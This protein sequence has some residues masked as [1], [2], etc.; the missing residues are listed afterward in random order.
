MIFGQYKHAITF[1]LV[2]LA[3]A[4]VVAD[5]GSDDV[6]DSAQAAAPAPPVPAAQP[7]P[8]RTVA[9]T[10]PEW[11]GE[12]V[13]GAEMPE[14][15]GANVDGEGYAVAPAATARTSVASQPAAVAAP[16]AQAGTDAPPPPPPQTYQP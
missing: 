13:G 9:S 12:P 16:A 5:P 7:R 3:L 11:Y 1:A 14:N 10:D 6:A 4:V 15:V 2:M 8:A